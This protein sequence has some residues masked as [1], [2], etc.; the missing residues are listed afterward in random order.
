MIEDG[1]H[2]NDCKILGQI[3]RRCAVK[4]IKHEEKKKVKE[5]DLYSAFIEVRYLTL[6]ALRY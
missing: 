4:Y 6:K 2:C 5:A 3:S 1:C